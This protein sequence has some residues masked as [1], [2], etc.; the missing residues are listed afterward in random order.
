MSG[1][2]DDMKRDLVNS[3]AGMTPGDYVSIMYFSSN[4]EY[5]YIIKDYQHVDMNSFLNLKNAIQLLKPISTT[6]FKNPLN[7]TLSAMGN[8]V[9]NNIVIFMS[10]GYENQNSNADVLNIVEKISN[11][12]HFSAGVVIEYGDYADHDMLVNMASYFGSFAYA[13][14]FKSFN[15]IVKNVIETHYTSKV[16]IVSRVFDYCF[17][18]VNGKVILYTNKGRIDGIGEY[19]VYVDTPIYA[20]S[21]S[22]GSLLFHKYE[23][24]THFDDP[25]FSDPVNDDDLITL[26]YL[27]QLSNDSSL[28]Y[29][30]ISTK[31]GYINILDA[32]ASAIGKTGVNNFLALLSEIIETP[33]KKNDKGYRQPS[34]PSEDAYCVYDC[35]NDLSADGNLVVIDDKNFVYSRI[36]AKKVQQTAVFSDEERQLL[37]QAKYVP[38]IAHIINSKYELKYTQDEDKGF[39]FDISYTKERA[40]VT[41]TVKRD[42]TIDTSVIPSFEIPSFKSHIFRRFAIIND[43]I[44]NIPK[45]VFYLNEDTYNILKNKDVIENGDLFYDAQK[46]YVINLVK[47]PLMNRTMLKKIDIDTFVELNVTS[48]V[49]GFSQK[50]VNYLYNKENPEK[51]IASFIEMYGAENALTLKEHGITENGFSPPMVALAGSD[52]YIAPTI[53]VKVKGF[54]SIPSVET[55]LNKV[56]DAKKLTKPE[57]LLYDKYKSIQQ[58]L[59]QGE[60][61]GDNGLE[62]LKN[63]LVNYKREVDRN[64]ALLTTTMMLNRYVPNTTTFNVSLSED[65]DTTLEIVMEDEVVLI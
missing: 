23:N 48:R 47:L 65:I 55:V 4:S 28:V 41:F 53:S 7:E 63:Y 60:Y 61:S 50:I 33:E 12:A 17:S 62:L 10:D 54:S 1:Q 27:A 5:G 64:I 45:L 21:F 39:P 52:S 26:L 32:Y 18:V 19:D 38:E 8:S 44:L 40:N 51:S 56:N 14:D 24:H 25:F 59:S 29:Y 16:S 57:Q 46:R 20:A 2:I 58:L 42:I 15:S 34:Q 9:S 11:H 43:L 6:G 49:A 35:L 37:G 13:K 36:G 31:L 3:F 30:L 22:D